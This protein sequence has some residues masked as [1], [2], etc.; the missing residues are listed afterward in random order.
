VVA[1]K[2]LAKKGGTKS[3]DSTS[4]SSESFSRREVSFFAC[5]SAGKQTIGFEVEIEG[6][7]FNLASVWVTL[8]RFRRKLPPWR[9]PLWKAGEMYF[10][11]VIE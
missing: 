6:C 11:L 4:K 1:A 2:K 5:G 8:S 10:L 9:M 7:P 3:K